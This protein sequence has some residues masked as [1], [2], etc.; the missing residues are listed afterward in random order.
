MRAVWMRVRSE[1]R[2][3]WRALAALA[4][5]VGLSGGVVLGAAAGARRTQTAY[6]RMLE[7]SRAHDVLVS[8]ATQRTLRS[9]FYEEVAALPGV[10]AAAVVAGVP[11]GVVGAEASS[12]I[13]Q[14]SLAALDD[15]FAVT[16]D[17]PNV[18]EGR[19]PAPGATDEVFINEAFA[20]ASGLG[21][22][23]RVTVRQFGD[24]GPIGPRFEVEITG[25][26]VNAV[27]VVPIAPLDAAPSFGIPAAVT[28]AHI[29]VDARGFDGIMI[30]LDPDVDIAGFER[31][32]RAIAARHPELGGLFYASQELRAA[33]VQRAL[34]P[35]EFAL[36][37]FA[38]L[39]G[40]SM[41]LVIA[42]ALARQVRLE[43]DEHE[44]AR[45]LGMSRAQI[46]AVA[47]VRAGIVSFAGAVLA[48]ALAIGSTALTPIGPAR[49]A[50]PDPGVMVNLGLLVGGVLIVAL[51]PVAAVAW[52][53][54]R[55]AR[56]RASAVPQRPSA[57][58]RGLAS[59]GAGP[60]VTVGVRMA[61]EPGRGRGAVPVRTTLAGTI[62][63]VVA[64]VAAGVF[65]ASLDRLVTTPRLYGLDWDRTIDTQFGR[66]FP[67][68]VE[69]ATRDPAVEAV[70]GG[71]YGRLTIEGTYVPAV[72]IDR[73]RGDVFPTIVRGAPPGEPDEI[74]LG[75]TTL[76][77]IDRAVGDRVRVVTEAGERDMTISGV[78]VF[79]RLGQGSFTPTALGEGAAVTTEVLPGGGMRPGEYHY[80]LI[81]MDG[82]PSVALAA[83]I[84]RLCEIVAS[85]GNPCGVPLRP[86]DIENY[87]SMRGTP[88][89]LTGVLAL[90][91][92]ATMTHALVTSVARRRR[93][94]AVLKT[95]GLARAQVRAAVAWQ[96]TTLTVVTLA[97]GLPFGV[98]GGRWAWRAFADQLGVFPAVTTP[99][100]T[101]ALA[102]AGAVVLANAIAAL[103]GRAAARTRPA[104][105]L[106]TE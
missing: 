10:R 67:S 73:I 46:F 14:A 36:S 94:L 28:R 99:G 11:L 31:D 106:R 68:L 97:L 75:A 69:A 32:V 21:A 88:L 42:Q 64:L 5:L 60:T 30:D 91:A 82:E 80:V 59:A 56:V 44:T 95:L 35:Q 87:A 23:D 26:T 72:G 98:A 18:L 55:A 53:T 24:A 8:G 27:E 45:A 77:R 15:A 83:E 63:A 62:I 93:E 85:R 48:V 12:A 49:L 65:G 39:T 13:E 47:M 40:I 70:A 6:P 50:E 19:L 104:L 103:P 92:L 16:V 102:A 4:L 54:W 81:R 25:V 96:A 105:V 86:A 57:I 3:R 20:D 84:A 79:P 43:A 33:V 9:G 78:A 22:G 74:V 66:V 34:R 17:R 100:A 37:T 58:A 51:A 2:A 52:P 71:T 89:L 41:L 101:L 76:R 61:L 38:A 1:L 90:L 7:A 29:D